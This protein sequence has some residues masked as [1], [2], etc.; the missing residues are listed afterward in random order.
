MNETC[1]HHPA[2]SRVERLATWLREQG[3]DAPGLIESVARAIGLDVLLLERGD[4]QHR[5]HRVGHALA[6]EIHQITKACVGRQAACIAAAVREVERAIVV[7]RRVRGRLDDGDRHPMADYARFSRL[8][9][10]AV[11]LLA[12]AERDDRQRA[13]MVVRARELIADLEEQ[14]VRVEDANPD[15][16]LWAGLDPPSGTILEVYDQPGRRPSGAAEPARSTSQG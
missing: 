8:A 11:S 7:L 4:K 10:E 9:D 16:P 1:Q 14:L 15:D 6:H 5:L 13:M 3:D 12:I 2:D